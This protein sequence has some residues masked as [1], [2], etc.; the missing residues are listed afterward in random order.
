LKSQLT[1]FE[2]PSEKTLPMFALCTISEAGF[3]ATS[4]P[5]M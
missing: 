2:P 3:V 5:K 4:D 1:P